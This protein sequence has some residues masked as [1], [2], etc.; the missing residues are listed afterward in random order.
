MR[1]HARPPGRAG[2]GHGAEVKVAAEARR[3]PATLIVART[4]A[5]T[6]HGIGRGVAPGEGVREGRG[7]RDLRRIA[8]SEVE[9]ERIGREVEKPLLANMV[10]FGKTPRVEVG[11]AEEMGLRR[12]DLSRAGNQ[13]RRRGDAAVLGFLKEKGTSRGVACHNTAT[14][15]S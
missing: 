3:D 11:Q 9:L 15:T 6:A 13:R 7:Q 2:R 8:E 5:R 1:P 14:C 10:E 4:D 12:G